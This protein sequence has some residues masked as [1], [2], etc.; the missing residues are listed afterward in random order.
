MPACFT[1]AIGRIARAAV[2]AGSTALCTAWLAAPSH[3]ATSPYPPISVGTVV[4]GEQR[5][6]D[7]SIP[8][9]VKF[10]VL[11]AA[12][13][14]VVLFVSGDA[15]QDAALSVLGLTSPVTVGEVKALFP[16]W[17][18]AFGAPTALLDDPSGALSLATPGCDATRCDYRATFVP[19]AEGVF[20]AQLV[21]TVASV[22]IQDGGLLGTLANLFLP[23]TLGLINSLLVFDFSGTALPVA[24]PVP[25]PGL[26][27][28]LPLAVALAGAG[29]L[30]IHRRRRSD[31]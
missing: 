24:A 22:T 20:D 17:A 6:V 21:L 7:V 16:D 12:F 11:P 8:L 9:S 14:G 28:L 13:D 30:A 19:Q 10:S 4:V 23:F 27:G 26:G 25:G 15:L 2:R 1:K 31:G 5:A 3:A 18:I 29:A